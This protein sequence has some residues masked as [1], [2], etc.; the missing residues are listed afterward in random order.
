MLQLEE[1]EV[2]NTDLRDT[3]EMMNSY[4]MI[5]YLKGLGYLR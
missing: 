1:I 5:F 3:N 2:E 4:G